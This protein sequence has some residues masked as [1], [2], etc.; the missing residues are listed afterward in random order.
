MLAELLLDWTNAWKAGLMPKPPDGLLEAACEEIEKHQNLIK[1]IRSH[2][3]WE[4]SYPIRVPF[5]YE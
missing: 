1:L 4:Q 3:K 2:P 5:I